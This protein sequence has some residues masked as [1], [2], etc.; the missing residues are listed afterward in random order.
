MINA[1][2]VLVYSDDAPATRTFFK[3]VLGLSFVSDGGSGE[4]GDWLIFAT[5]PS[6]VGVHPTQG[7][8]DG[9]TFT[10]PRHHQLSLMTTDIEATATQVRVKGG[11]ILTGPSDMGFGIGMEIEVPG[12]DAILI[13]QP[14]HATAY[15]K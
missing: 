7:E 4:P 12:T 2:H 1:V 8:F 3:D 11:H 6:E 10:A 9:E 15:D 5:G 13:Y 14:K